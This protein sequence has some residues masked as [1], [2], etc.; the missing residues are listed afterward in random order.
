MEGN[1]VMVTMSKRRTLAVMAGVLGGLVVSCARSNRSEA[2]FRPQRVDASMFQK[3][4]RPAREMPPPKI[5]PQTHFA[6]GRLFE[7]RGQFAKAIEQYRKATLVN[8]DYFEAFHRLGVLLSLT[9]QH[10]EAMAALT[11]AVELRPDDAFAHNNLGFELMLQKRLA[12][13]ENQYRQAI[14]LKP[15]FARA[16]I[17]LGIVQA[18]QH[19]FDEALASFRVVLPDVDAYYN[20]GLMYRAQNRFAEAADAFRHVLALNPQFDAAR[21][22]LERLQQEHG[23]PMFAGQ[24]EGPPEDARGLVAAAE[25]PQ[26][27]NDGTAF[28]KTSPPGGMARTSSAG[29]VREDEAWNEAVRLFDRAFEGNTGRE[30][31]STSARKTPRRTPTNPTFERNGTPPSSMVDLDTLLACVE[32]PPVCW[33]TETPM[34][35][36]VSKADRRQASAVE[37]FFGPPFDTFRDAD[38]FSSAEPCEDVRVVDTEAMTALTGRSEDE[39]VS[40]ADW[41]V[42][43]E[44]ERIPVC[45]ADTEDALAEGDSLDSHAL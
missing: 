38:A 28:E 30:S 42:R 6:A 15:D 14:V 27:G 33:Q 23:I 39:L 16:Y 32:D 22:Q 35:V 12:E 25:Q 3:K 29:Q 36:R 26:K 18:R 9:G 19:R 1:E 37:S 17:N 24:P 21:R 2:W 8:H 4:F 20:V 5:L 34:V 31:T 10:E 7:A 45:L 41:G 44:V 13:A 43:V 40:E 11:R